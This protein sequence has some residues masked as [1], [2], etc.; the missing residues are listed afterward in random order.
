MHIPDGLIGPRTYLTAYALAV[1]W[2]AWC[3]RHV[4]ARLEAVAI[5]RLAVL[6]ALTFVLAS[7][8][9]PLPGG[10]A[11]HIT[12]VALLTLVFGLPTASL[13]YSL[14]LALQALL[15]GA[16]GITTLP[17][18]A[19]AMGLIGG[20]VTL[21]THRVLRPMHRATAIITGTWLGVVLAAV[22]VA[23]VLGAQPWLAED[24]AGQPLFFP[25]GWR[26]TLPAVV[27]PHLL[28]AAGEGVLTW[29]V[30]RRLDNGARHG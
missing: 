30:I 16:G 10:T 24:A 3:V 19:L 12:G 4:A 27:G 2:W 29:L 8:M 26:V 20:L 21:G 13:A 28:I 5:P 14:V 1:P 23:L 22:V 9:V 15:F 18:N 7:I 11:G 6:T 17:I 25:F